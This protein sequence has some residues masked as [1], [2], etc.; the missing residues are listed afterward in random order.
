VQQ[1]KLLNMRKLLIKYTLPLIVLLAG[2]LDACTEEGP[3]NR[4]EQALT[5]SRESILVG[6]AGE[7]VYVTVSSKSEEWTLS[8]YE[9]WCTPDV[10]EGGAG[11]TRIAVTFLDNDDPESREAQLTIATSS[12]SKTINIKQLGTGQIVQPPGRNPEYPVNEKIFDEVFSKW[13]YWDAEV[14]KT[15]ADFNQDYQQFSRNYF[16]SPAMKDNSAD[17]RIW[18]TIN[19]RYLYTYVERHPLDVL[20]NKFGDVRPLGFGMEFDV[21]TLEGTKFVARILYVQPGSPAAK[22]GLRRG[23]WIRRINDKELGD[24]NYKRL[25]DSLARPDHG[26]PLP[27]RIV[28][29]T[30]SGQIDLTGQRDVVITPERFEGNP[31]L[32]SEVIAHDSR[33]GE[34]V[35]TGYL[36]YNSFD[37]NY[38][39]E[40]VTVFDG[41][42]NHTVGGETVG[43]NNLIVDLR[44]N[45]SGVTEM[46]ELMGDLIAPESARGKTFA[47]YTFNSQNS[48][49]DRTKTFEPHASS[50]G[51]TTVII[52]A[53]GHTAGAAELLINA[54]NGLGDVRLILVGGITGGMN[55]G[56]YRKKSA[57]LNNEYIYDA[58]SLAFSCTNGNDMG[59]YQYG[60]V[61][62]APVDEWSEANIVWPE[63]WTWRPGAK[64]KDAL[65]VKAMQYADGSID[66]PTTVAQF[67]TSGNISGYPRLFS[68]RHSMIME[69][70]SE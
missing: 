48:A 21:A 24:W 23:E 49:L 32:H 11:Q 28:Q 17:G 25:T 65:L 58:Y 29:R 4:P 38:R 3:D 64:Y 37:P 1:P 33:A 2:S 47:T 6:G 62:H 66:P 63:E 36:V 14:A 5:V 52:I 61:P 54:F 31:I 56:M 68:V 40:L 20:P 67:Q 8:G 50:V 55:T 27:L 16:G 59:G 13:Y 43:I 41:F 57:A 35:Y 42:K 46:A 9:D 19:E 45:K 39:D 7:T 69:S 30:Y 53:T 70:I 44:Y 18:A 10:I 34:R 22:A 51:M 15:P 60:I 12:Y 26:L